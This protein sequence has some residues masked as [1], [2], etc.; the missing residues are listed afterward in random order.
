MAPKSVTPEAPV[1]DVPVEPNGK[2][3]NGGNKPNPN[4]R[5]NQGAPEEPNPGNQQGP[6]NQ[7]EPAATGDQTASN[8]PSASNA[9]REM[10][11]SGPY[12]D[13]P[14]RPG[15]NNDHQPSNKSWQ[16]RA[17]GVKGEEPLTST[18]INRIRDGAPAVPIETPNHQ[19]NSPTYGGRQHQQTPSGLPRKEADALDPLGSAARDSQATGISPAESQRIQQQAAEFQEYIDSGGFLDENN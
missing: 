16:I 4:K 12:G 15:I 18:E 5:P 13:L 1:G 19:A 2:Y 14:K 10:G 17:Q 9:G 8:A 11:P 3:S 7:G 6:P